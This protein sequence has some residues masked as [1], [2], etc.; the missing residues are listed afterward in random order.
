MKKGF[1]LI[2][3]L[4]VI[5]IIGILSSVVLTQLGA[6]RGKGADVGIISNLSAIRTQ[7]E[8]D[9]DSAASN[10]YG[11]TVA[12]V[13]CINPGN[14]KF[15]AGTYSKAISQALNLSG[16]KAKSVCIVTATGWVV[17]VPLKTDNTNA[18][19]VDSTGNQKKT[20]TAGLVS[21]ITACP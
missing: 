4:V 17:G 5:A 1:T 19:C 6:A 18:W 2:E 11:S 21:S 20:P 10:V 14:S 12:D 16:D 8:I 15:S 9:F 13:G 7:F 3:L